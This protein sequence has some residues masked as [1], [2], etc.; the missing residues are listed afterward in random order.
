MATTAYTISLVL[1]ATKGNGL[2]DLV[3]E[4]FVGQTFQAA[5]ADGRD[6]NKAVRMERS[7]AALGAR[8]DYIEMIAFV[9]AGTAG[10]VPK[11]GCFFVDALDF[12]GVPTAVQHTVFGEFSP[13]VTPKSSMQ[14]S[15][16]DGIDRQAVGLTGN[17]AHG[18]AACSTATAQKVRG[19]SDSRITIYADHLDCESWTK[20]T[21]KMKPNSDG[22]IVLPAGGIIWSEPGAE[23]DVVEASY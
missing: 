16:L 13:F 1:K 18:Q 4:D 15:M 14:E 23:F 5:L 7:L 11:R 12:T 17:V 22:V 20:V 2:A 21:M 19:V 6:V 8:G 10:N 3:T 9:S